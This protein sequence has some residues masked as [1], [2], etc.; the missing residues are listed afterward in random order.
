[1]SQK[2]LVGKVRHYY[3]RIGV[4]AVELVDELSV[5]DTISIEKDGAAVE[6]KVA[7]LQIERASVTKAFSGDSVGIKTEVQVSEGSDVYKII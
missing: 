5:G 1:M 3:S 2:I 7:S 4:A 6:Q